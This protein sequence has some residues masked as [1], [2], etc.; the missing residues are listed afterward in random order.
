MQRWARHM[1]FWM[2]VY[3]IWTYMKTF[4]DVHASHLIVN[5]VHLAAYIAVYYSLKEVLIPRYFDRERWL[6]FGLGLIGSTVMIVVIWNTILYGLTDYICIP[7]MTIPS[8]YGGYI[9]E[10]VQMFVPGMILLAGES[11]E[12]QQTEEAKRHLLEKESITNELNYL[13]A[14]INPQ[15]IFNTLHNLKT[16]VDKKSPKAPDMILRLSEV[17]DYVLYRSQEDSVKL[18]EE[19]GV[20]RGFIALEKLRLGNKLNI[21]LDTMGDLLADIAPLTLLTVV[22]NAL[23]ERIIKQAK[24][25][26]VHIHI[27]STDDT[28]TCKVIMLKYDKSNIY[29]NGLTEIRRQLALTYP[30]HHT[31]TQTEDSGAIITSLT[32]MTI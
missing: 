17:L 21:Q 23:K 27:Q 31:L 6:G 24:Q 15:F 25:L 11:Y 19:V 2:G 26:D 7:P 9:L 5:I 20:I 12:A 16:F 28:V 30:G 3:V 10:G 8:T 13:K 1:L 29:G 32:L 4:G 22:E 14:K 18:Q